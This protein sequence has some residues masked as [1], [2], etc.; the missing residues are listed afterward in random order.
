MARMTMTRQKMG[1]EIRNIVPA[2]AQRRHVNLHTSEAVVTDRPETDPRA[3]R[4][5]S[6]RFVAATIRVLTRFAPVAPT[7]S[8][9]SS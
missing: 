9:D 5:A 6:G 7:R 3:T 2:G 1:G 4:S 8:T